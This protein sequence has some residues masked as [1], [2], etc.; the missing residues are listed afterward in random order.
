VQALAGLDAGQAAVG[1]VLAEVVMVRVLAALGFTVLADEC[2][3]LGEIR[4]AG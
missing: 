3:G 2:N 4:E 1:A